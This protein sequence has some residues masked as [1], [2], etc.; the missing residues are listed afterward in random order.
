MMGKQQKSNWRHIQS[1]WYEVILI[2]NS[3]LILEG[4]WCK[5]RIEEVTLFFKALN[6]H[7]NS[8]LFTS[9]HHGFGFSSQSLAYLK[10]SR[11]FLFLMDATNSACTNSRNTLTLSINPS[12]SNSFGKQ[13]RIS[14]K[15]IYLRENQG[16]ANEDLYLPHL[17]SICKRSE[18]SSTAGVAAFVHM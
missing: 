1:I 4:K 10:S 17:L 15:A 3:L 18:C 6:D 13:V 9:S 16:T 7:L 2:N 11:S 5:Q 14:A 12:L 8:T